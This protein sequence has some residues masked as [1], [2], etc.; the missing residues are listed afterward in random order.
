MAHPTSADPPAVETV[1][2]TLDLWCCMRTVPYL[3]FLNG[4]DERPWP[5]HGASAWVNTECAE[6]PKYTAMLE[7]ANAKAKALFFF[8]LALMQIGCYDNLAVEV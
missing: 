5:S 2:G 6:L 7:R 8:A 1:P 3:R 4:L